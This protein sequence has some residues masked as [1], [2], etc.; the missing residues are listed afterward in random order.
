M[1]FRTIAY[2]RFQADDDSQLPDWE[3]V[4][5]YNLTAA[6]RAVKDERAI[7]TQRTTRQRGWVTQ[8]LLFKMIEKPCLT[9]HSA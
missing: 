4:G 7:F 3:P 1:M 2:R 9:G 5:V 6:R 8:H